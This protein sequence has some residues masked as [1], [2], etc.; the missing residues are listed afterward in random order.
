MAA[1]LR[2]KGVPSEAVLEDEAGTDTMKTARHTA[3]LLGS[4]TSV[5]VVSQWFHLPRAILAMRRF[6][7]REVSGDWPH[8]F[9]ARDVYSFIREAVALPFYATRSLYSGR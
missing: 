9:E 2:A 5:V 8:W 7:I 4:E 6:G 1:Y 3:K